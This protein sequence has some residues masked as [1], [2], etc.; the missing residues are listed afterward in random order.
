MHYSLCNLSITK[1]HK[2]LSHTCSSVM[3][4]C[5]KKYLEVCMLPLDDKHWGG[6]LVKLLKSL[7]DL[8]LESS[9]TVSRTARAECSRILTKEQAH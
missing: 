1:N 8:V 5:L 2:N 3:K 4:Y 7:R 9:G 6:I